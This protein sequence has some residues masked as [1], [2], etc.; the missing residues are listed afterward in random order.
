MADKGFAANLRE[1]RIAKKETQQQL[2]NAIGVPRSTI[3]KWENSYLEADHAALKAVA[4]HYRVTID[5]LLR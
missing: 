2:A 1:L 4:H 3:S 5:Q